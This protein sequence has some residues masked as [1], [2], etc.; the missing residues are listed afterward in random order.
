M[1][2]E[3]IRCCV[4]QFWMDVVVSSGL[5]VFAGLTSGLSL[6]LLSHSKV[7]LEVLV[8]AGLPKD[9]KNAAKVLPLVKNECFL[10]C[11]LLIAKSLA[12]EAL[13]LFLDRIL[14]FWFAILVSIILVVAFV[15]VIPQA[16][17]T[18][19]GLGFGAKL[20]LFV[21]L[22]LL[23]LSPVSYPVSKVLDWLL[24]ENHPLIFRRAELKTLVDLHGVKAGKGGDLTDDET[25]IIS[26]ALGMVEKKAKDAMTPLS[27][28]F[29]LDINSKFDLHTMK[30]ISGKGHSRVP[31]YSDN[32]ANIIG[33]ILVK[34]LMLYHPAEETPIRKLTIRR[35]LRVYESWSLF[36]VLKLFQ[37]GHGHMAVVV[38]SDVREGSDNDPPRIIIESDY[39]IREREVLEVCKTPSRSTS[40]DILREHLHGS[41]SNEEL[42]SLTSRFIDEEVIGII[43][44]ED[45]LEELLQEQIMDETDHHVEM[46]DKIRVR[47]PSSI[48]SSSGKWTTA[49]ASFSSLSSPV[50]SYISPSSPKLHSPRSLSTLRRSLLVHQL[51][52]ISQ[53]ISRKSD[54]AF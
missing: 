33:L 10:L 31:I 19:H 26:G 44:M 14:P 3:Y 1:G 20:A 35:I 41:I 45:V 27:K 22:L 30:T 52:S 24:G 42:E 6:G 37:E 12:T 48:S 4:R 8:K 32:P 5:V 49:A 47:F 40:L 15:E 51:S 39:K 25:N 16:V 18:R 17:C 21:R 34:N 11:T 13:P 43:T 9:R 53:H 54:Q 29:S 36:E 23:I 50:P 28:A 2:E 38:K 46:H 7:D